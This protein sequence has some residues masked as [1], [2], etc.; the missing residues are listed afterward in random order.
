MV[1]SAESVTMNVQQN[2]VVAQ[3]TGHEK[4]DEVFTGFGSVERAYS[5]RLARNA[6]LI[7]GVV[8]GWIEPQLKRLL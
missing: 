3:A 2:L 7:H 4:L 1:L 6:S 5:F 8:L